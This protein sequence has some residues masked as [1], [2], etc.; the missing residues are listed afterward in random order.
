MVPTVSFPFGTLLTDQLTP[1]FIV[2]VTVAWNC[3]VLPASTVAVF[4]EITTLMFELATTCAVIAEE[5]AAPGFGL[6]T[7]T[8]TFPISALVAL[9]VSVNSGEE[10]KV[11]GSACEPKF[12]TDPFTSPVPVGVSVKAPTIIVEGLML[13]I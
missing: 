7:V 6:V 8:G 5:V 10:K 13:A 12:T 11:V 3:V 1:V 2:P 4:G 9:R